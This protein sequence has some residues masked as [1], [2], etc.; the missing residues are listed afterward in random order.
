MPTSKITLIASNAVDRLVDTK[1]QLIK[2]QP[3]GP[4]YYI[5]DVFEQEKISFTALSQRP[6][7]VE[8]MISDK[9]ERGRVV[10]RPQPLMVPFADIKTPAVV[11]SSIVDEI[12]IS[13]LP[14]YHGQVFLDV[15]GFVRDGGN[16][17]AKK[18]WY[19]NPSTM[20]RV[21]CLKATAEE[22][23][24]VSP[25]IVDNQ[26][27]A[28]LLVTLGR[29]GSI[30]YSRGEE[31]RVVPQNIIADNH[32]IGAGDTLFAY[33]VCAVVQGRTPLDSLKWATEQTSIFLEQ[34]M[35]Q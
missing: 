21:T 23:Q 17:G 16:F 29:A 25:D 4:A 20:K 13:T 31:Y 34:T 10:R 15:Q 19:P 5:A 1:N 12:D 28:M 26:K 8:I 6:L 18:P 7:E 3:G 24:F 9:D 2:V 27:K 14:T 11:L 33:F 22:L 30:L 35:R 32:T